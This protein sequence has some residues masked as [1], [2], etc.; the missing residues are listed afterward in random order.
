[1]PEPEIVRYT[2]AVAVLTRDHDDGDLQVLLVRRPA[3]HTDP[4][5][6]FWSLPGGYVDL[7]ETAQQAAARE[8]VEETGLSVPAA[9]LEEVGVFDDPLPDRPLRGCRYVTMAFWVVVRGNTTVTAG[10]DAAEA[11]WRPTRQTTGLAFD[12]DAIL[13][14]AL[15]LCGE[16]P[17]SGVV[18]LRGY[19]V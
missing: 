14:H 6:G 19:T 18:T 1:M 13:A 2:V 10:D 4:F 5:A 7:E 17:R 11:L 9:W 3:E 16:T 15:R 12:D 8:L